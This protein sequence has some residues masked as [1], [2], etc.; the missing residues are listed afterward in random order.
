MDS[1]KVGASK[2]GRKQAVNVV[3]KEKRY[4][5]PDKIPD[6]FELR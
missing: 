2:V 4:V 6:G 1:K 3:T 5:F